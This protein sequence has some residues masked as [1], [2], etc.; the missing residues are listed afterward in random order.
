[1]DVSQ[2]K[3]RFGPAADQASQAVSKFQGKNPS[4]LRELNLSGQ[5]LANSQVNDLAKLLRDKHSR[6]NTLTLCVCSIKEEQCVFL[7]S[8]LKSN[9]S[10]LRE[11]NLTG[12]QIQN[13]GLNHFC[14]ILK[15]SQCK[16]ER[17]RWRYS[18]MTY[19]GCSA[20]TS[21]L[22]LNPSHLRELNLSGNNLE[23]S[24]VKNLSDFLMNPQCRLEKLLVCGC[25]IT[26]E[27]CAILTSAL[28][29]NPSHLR[30]LN[31]SWNN[32]GD[33]GVKNLSDFLMNPQCRLEKLHLCVC[34]ITEEQCII[35][36]SAL[37]SNPSHLRE[38]NLT[39][40]Q[41]ENTGLNHICDILKNSQL[42]LQRPKR[43]GPAADPACQDENKFQGKNP[44]LLRELNLSGQTLRDAEVKELDKLLRDKRCW[45]NTLTLC[46][47]SI[48]E[49][50]CVIL[51]SALKSNPSHLRELNLTGNQIENTLV[52]HFCDLLNDTQCKLEILRWRY[53][54]MTYEGCSAVT[55]ALNS[56]PSHLRELNLSGNNLGDSG[57]KNLS[58]FLM[59]PRCRLEKLLVCGCSITEEQCVILTSALNSNP[60]HLRELN[61]SWNNLG[62]SGV[63]NLSD[64]LMNPQCR[65]EKLQLRGSFMTYEGCSAV[66]SALNSNPSHL[67]EL[68][69]SGNNLGDSG[70]KNLSDFLMNPRC[71]LEKLLVCGCSITEEQCVILTSAL[72][73][74]PSHLRELNLSWNNLGDSGVKN[75]SDFLMNPQ[76]RLEKLLL[77]V[78]SI[79]EEQCVFLTSALRS[80]P[81]HLRELNLTGNQIQNTGFNHICDI[82]KNSQFKLQRLKLSDCNLTEE[83]YKALALALRSNPSHLI[84]LDL[85]RNDPGE[86]G[87]KELT[88][89]LKDRNSQL[90]TLRFLSPAA[91]KP[92]Q[93]AIKAQGKNPL[94]ARELN[95]S[96]HELGYTQVKELDE[97]LRD[98]HCRINILILWRCTITAK[99][100]VILTSA[101]K[102]V[103]SHLR[104]LH[105]SWNNLRDSG[106]NLSDFL[107]NPECTVDKL[108]V[109]GCSI[110]E[111]QCVIL[112]SALNSNPSHLRELNLS[113]NNLG[114]SGVK[115]LSD[116]LMNPQCR[117]EKLH[118][119]GCSITVEQ[120]VILTSAL[121]SNPSHLRELNLSNNNLKDS[122]EKDG[123][124]N[125]GV[126]KLCKVLEDSHCELEILRL[127]YC[128][129]TDES[130]S[131]V[132]LALRSNPSHLRELNLSENQIENTGLNHLCDILKNSQCKL[133]R[134]SVS[135]CGIT[136]VSFLTQSLRK[137]KKVL[138]FLKELD[139]RFNSIKDSQQQLI[140]V[141]QH[142]NCKLSIDTRGDKR[143]S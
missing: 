4:L 120:C 10:H 91:D 87:V 92:C 110:T 95:L 130:C 31:L 78:C 8:A 143:H 54:F 137:A 33:S 64:F 17:L 27:Q 15:N 106:A 58:D 141:V 96:G 44:S 86:S 126:K 85:R 82:L 3:R 104:E 109:C 79:T 113:W 29:S 127:S 83:G 12:N 46:V 93:L 69:L 20:V 41:M 37:K 2:K 62:D 142:S 107:K 52:N 7:T 75:L 129:L 90:K 98:K 74:N 1:M 24:G 100:S 112:T 132:A 55:S 43:Y 16:L 66:T 50:Q 123:N 125:T 70:V 68:N 61:L 34:G 49:E 26:E 19:E 6:I 116:F 122:G 32:L 80:N 11:L 114:D 63:K 108:H 77:C 67:R 135:Y 42:K 103:V 131:A 99:G 40:N 102:S 45:L 94:L 14:D 81:S 5:T 56:N 101:L 28:N 138:Q 35:L 118:V 88:D 119:C 71:R 97:L 73:S 48:T 117:L 84:E 65:L 140:D 121:K 136:D 25:S 111:E 38:L 124:E 60:S 22:N 134:L 89:V 23:D 13:T 18:F 53:C 115:N 9:P 39:G 47:C 76:C 57:V 30:E 139:L 51:T 21:A 105:L 59:N 128:F 36:N 72:N 133:E